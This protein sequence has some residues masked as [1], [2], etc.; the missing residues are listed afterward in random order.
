LERL[1]RTVP[2]AQPPQS[3]DAVIFRAVV[4]LDFEGVVAKRWADPYGK[5]TRWLKVKNRNYSQSRGRRELFRRGSKPGLVVDLQG[6][7]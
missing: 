5:R 3:T 2:I 7:G 4:E 6:S 1:L